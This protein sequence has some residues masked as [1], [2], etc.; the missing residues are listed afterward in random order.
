VRIATPASCIFDFGAGPGMDAKFY[1]ERGLQVI[2]Y[3][4]D[5]RMCAS[6][7]RRCQG[8]M[9]AGQISL[10]EGE[11]GEF[12]GRLAPALRQQY[13]VELVTCNFAP[14]N[15][16]EDLTGLFHA[17]HKLSAPRARILASVLNP[18]FVG[19]MRR[20]WWWAGRLT[21][22]R[23]GRFTTV[24][25]TGDVIRRS[26]ADFALQ[27]AP[28]FRLDMVLRGLPGRAGPMVKSAGPWSLANSRYMFLLFA[29]C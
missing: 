25:P 14:L 9:E 3:D 26:R 23:C 2:A 17:L 8:E 16:I 13:A 4:H 24:G 12:L 5:P 15:L 27:A 6:F 1:A 19:D 18:W 22:L 20:S 11:Y 10:Y 29:K 7:A 21:Y 28:H